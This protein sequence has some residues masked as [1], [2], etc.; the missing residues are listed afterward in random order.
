MNAQGV[1]VRSGQYHRSEGHIEY[2]HGIMYRGS[3]TTPARVL[4]WA[5][6]PLARNISRAR[7]FV[8]V[9]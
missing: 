1:H 5:P 9:W 7:V 4:V 3:M 6:C 2:G 8:W